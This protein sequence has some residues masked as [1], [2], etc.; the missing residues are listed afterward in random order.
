ML[1]DNLP[2]SPTSPAPPL[3][4]VSVHAGAYLAHDLAPAMP[5]ICTGARTGLLG[6]T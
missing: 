4:T 6:E 2:S 5:R 1:N 3:T